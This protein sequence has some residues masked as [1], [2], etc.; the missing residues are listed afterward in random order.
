MQALRTALDT[1]GFGLDEVAS[2]SSSSS[3]SGAVDGAGALREQ[4]ARE[5]AARAKVTG[6]A[7]GVAREISS[8][9]RFLND[10]AIPE[11]A[12]LREE[13]ERIGST[14]ER[15]VRADSERDDLT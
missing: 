4:A 1:G 9:Q 10:H 12:V 2:S 7:M 15:V 11:L 3:S 8:L 6:A 14:L 5:R 13:S